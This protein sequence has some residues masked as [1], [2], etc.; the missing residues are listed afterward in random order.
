MRSQPKKRF[1]LWFLFAVL[2]FFGVVLRI[3]R[4]FW[5]Q[6]TPAPIAR[7][8]T[9]PLRRWLD[10]PER[11]L[12]VM[13]VNAGMRVLE[14]GPGGGFYTGATAQRVGPSGML[15]AADLSPRL[16]RLVSQK[17]HRQGMSWVHGVAANAEDLPL[18][19]QQ[20]DLA[21]YV[22]VIGEVP[23][24]VQALREARRVLRPGGRAFLVEFLPDPDYP[25]PSTSARWAQQAG[26]RPGKPRRIWIGYALELK[27]ESPEATCPP[28]ATSSPI[29]H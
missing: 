17:T 2:F 21:F 12:N 29:L 24:R 7:L 20:F 22:T 18:A 6:A 15:C 8:L 5:P 13:G 10:P 27:K 4:K 25:L 19:D 26:L 14:V 11:L 1:A 23:D 16:A 9:N 3:I 28:G